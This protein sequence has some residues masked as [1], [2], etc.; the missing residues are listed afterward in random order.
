MWSPTRENRDE[1]MNESDISLIICFLTL[2]K[3][4]NKWIAYGFYFDIVFIVF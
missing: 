1:L 2:L 4:A 3:T